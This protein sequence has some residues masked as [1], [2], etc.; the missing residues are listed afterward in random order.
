MENNVEKSGLQRFNALVQSQKTTE[1]LQSVLGENAKSFT[2]SL[3]S[4]VANNAALQKCEPLGV[5][6]SAMKAATLNLPLET[7]LGFAY[8][9]PYTSRGVTEAQFQIGYKGLV[10]LCIRSGQFTRINVSDVREGEFISHDILTGD[11]TIRAAADRDGLPVVGYVAYFRLVNGFEKSMYWTVRQIQEHAGKY[12]QTAKRGYGMWVEEFDSM[13]KKT[14]LKLLLSKY[15]PM[16]LDLQSA[17]IADQAV[18][19]DPDVPSYVDND[20]RTTIAEMAVEADAA[21]DGG[22][23]DG[24]GA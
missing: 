19:R 20:V 4:L 13:A 7:N 16:S 22:P 6:Y 15:A 9:I 2:T 12:S 18:F 3:V 8:V 21:N 1:Y 11:M 24:H 14:V 10:Q 5:M 17:V 23:E